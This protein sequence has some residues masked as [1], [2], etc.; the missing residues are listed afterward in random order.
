[1]AEIRHLSIAE[2]IA[3]HA[4][5]MERTG[6]A[7]APLV[8]EGLLESAIRRTFWASG[9]MPPEDLDLAALAGVSSAV[10]SPRR[11][12]SSMATSAQPTRQPMSFCASTGGDMGAIRSK[13]RSGWKTLANY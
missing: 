1:M 5:V 10:G 4:A 12:H 7:P 2:V 13:W 9:C 8:Q 6:F 11:R 3:L